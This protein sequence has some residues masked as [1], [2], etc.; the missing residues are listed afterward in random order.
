M[1]VAT[2][3]QHR[4][5]IITAA[6][7]LAAALLAFWLL[8]AGMLI[9]L[10]SQGTGQDSGTTPPS[11]LGD[12]G[13]P[14]QP[15]P[16]ATGSIAHQQD[17]NA[18]AIAKV[19]DD[20]GLGGHVT[21]IAVTAAD[22]E[23]DLI[24][25]DHGDSAGPDSRGL[26][27]QRTGWGTEAQ[28]M[29][30]EYATRSFLLG[31]KHDGK[32]HGPGSTGLVAIKGWQ[33][34]SISA[35]IHAVQGNADPNHYTQYVPRAE[36]IAGRAKID[37]SKP[38]KNGN[39]KD[40]GST[41]EPGDICGGNV[42][43]GSLA[44][45][46]IAAEKAKLGTPY[47]L[48]GGTPQGPTVGNTSPAGWDCSSYVQMAFWQASGGKINLPRTTYEQVDSPL[49]VPVPIDKIKPGDL[50]FV[51]T[52]GPA[53]GWSHVV[54]YIGAGKIIEEPHTREVSR[55]MPLSEY[56]GMPQTARRVTGKISGGS[57]D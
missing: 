13:V 54:L 6:I 23:S 19:V 32:A 33:Q 42:N 38:A 11:C 8:A 12:P 2:L 44:A 49:V 45:K 41:D 4:G 10:M 7:V 52:E 14:D 47:S 22:G 48:G 40:P 39:T 9:G 53:A 51:Q 56:S 37:L 55:I 27:Q 1:L 28:R 20:L 21:L 35:A 15:G 46:A 57:G 18:T 50:I 24:N 30:P 34:M 3:V 17:T 43:P 31:P 25:L 16:P 26:F 36:Q 29:T 5:K